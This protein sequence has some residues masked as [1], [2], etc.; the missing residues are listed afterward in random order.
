MGY[1]KG[2]KWK[3]EATMPGQKKKITGNDRKERKVENELKIE[4][5]YI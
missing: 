2:Q 4:M 3:G 1:N 5:A